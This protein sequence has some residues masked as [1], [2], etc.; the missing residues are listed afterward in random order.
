MYFYKRTINTKKS[1]HWLKCY[2]SMFLKQKRHCRQ[3]IQCVL[4]TFCNSHGLTVRL[5]VTHL[6]SW[7]HSLISKSQ[8]FPT[9]YVYFSCSPKINFW[10]MHFLAILGA[11]EQFYYFPSLIRSTFLTG[12]EYGASQAYLALMC[13]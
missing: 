7:S 1:I 3:C 12:R 5:R 9:W 4:Q 6:I 11:F 2:T 8:G 13:R 10:V